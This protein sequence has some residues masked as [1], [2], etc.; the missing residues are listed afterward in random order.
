MRSY[1][2]LVELGDTIQF[3]QKKRVGTKTHKR[4][5]TGV[6]EID[7]RLGY[8]IRE[9]Q[10]GGGGNWT[11]SKGKDDIT[12]VKKANEPYELGDVIE[13]TFDD[14]VYQGAI[15]TI[16]RFGYWI[17]SNP[18]CIGA[19]SRRCGFDYPITLVKKATIVQEI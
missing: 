16:G 4:T 18:S 7:S 19:G 1:D 15:E 12:L 13:Y 17:A 3:V 2:N 8:W 14:Y 11:R 6:V 9:P 10:T 5:V